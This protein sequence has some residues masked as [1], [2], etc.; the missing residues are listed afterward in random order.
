MNSP[1]PTIAHYLARTPKTTSTHCRSVTSQ[2]AKSQG[3]TLK[4]GGATAADT[5]TDASF[6]EQSTKNV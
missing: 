5:A 1:W 4:N 3:L 2:T 6:G